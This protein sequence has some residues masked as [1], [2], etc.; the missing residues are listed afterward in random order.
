[1]TRV[2][3]GLAAVLMAVLATLL[4]VPVQGLRVVGADPT[5]LFS[6]AWLAGVLPATL[7]SVGLVAVAAVGSWLL[8]ARP[9]WPPG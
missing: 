6:S 9:G 7:W 8:R 5:S 1:M 2:R 4:L 3:A